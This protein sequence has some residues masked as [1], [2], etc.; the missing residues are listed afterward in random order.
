MV[1][2]AHAKATHKTSAAS[3]QAGLSA[4]IVASHGRHFVAEDEQGNLWQVYG[5]G[6]R[7]EAAVGDRVLIGPSGDRQ[8]WIESIE[9]RRNLLY[10]SDA[11]RSKLFA[12]NLDLVMLVLAAS[13]PYSPE[14]LGRTWVACKAADIPLELVFNKVDLIEDN[15]EFLEDIASELEEWTLGEVPIHW[16]SLKQNPEEALTILR[17]RLEDR[18]SLILGQSGMGKS[19]LINHLIPGVNLATNEVSMALNTGKHTTTN[20]EMHRGPEGLEL[21]D[22]PG[23]Q[24]FG[25]HHLSPAELLDVFSDVRAEGLRCRFDDCKHREEP[26]CAVKEALDDGHLSEARFALYQLLLAELADAQAF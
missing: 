3:S 10:R 22:S 21:I 26:A 12:A 25:L 5:K 9:P 4:R 1:K 2:R 17:P 11:L 15:P 20:T 16:V 6:K 23:F 8:A 24:A 19:T 7:R 18:C 13:P 14:L